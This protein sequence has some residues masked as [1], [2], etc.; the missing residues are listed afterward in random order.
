[1][2]KLTAKKSYF[3]G[4]FSF[5]RSKMEDNGTLNQLHI[6]QKRPFSFNFAKNILFQIFTIFAHF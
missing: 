6:H 3:L 1:M 2:H 5:N 4:I